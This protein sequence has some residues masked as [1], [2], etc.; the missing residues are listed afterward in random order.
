MANFIRTDLAFTKRGWFAWDSDGD[1]GKNIVH[2]RIK[3][4]GWLV[5]KGN[6]KT[7]IINKRN[8]DLYWEVDNTIN[9]V[10][11]AMDEAS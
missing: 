2:M 4:I 3:E 10:I 11:K 6:G 5:D 9:E 8:Y 7:W 1:N